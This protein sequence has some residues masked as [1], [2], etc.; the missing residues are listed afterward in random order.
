M[1]SFTPFNTSLHLFTNSTGAWD[2]RVKSIALIKNRLHVMSIFCGDLIE[3]IGS[4]IEATGLYIFN[5]FISS[6]G[7]LDFRLECI[8]F[9]YISSLKLSKMDTCLVSL[10]FIDNRPNA[11]GVI[12]RRIYS[13]HCSVMLDARDLDFGLIPFRFFNSWLQDLNLANM[14]RDCWE[15]NSRMEKLFSKVELLSKKRRALKKEIKNWRAKHMKK[16]NM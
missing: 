10:N 6:I 12:L 3:R 9:T 2:L 1:S 7:L 13:N 8:S 15:T 4:L 14:V 16:T 5:D 11:G